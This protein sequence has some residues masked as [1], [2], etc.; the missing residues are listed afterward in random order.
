ME[1]EEGNGEGRRKMV[2]EEENGEGRMERWR[3]S[4]RLSCN[5]SEYNG[6]LRTNS[7]S[8]KI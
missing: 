4:L 6:L 5:M 2:G 7:Y 8:A 1:R 3:N